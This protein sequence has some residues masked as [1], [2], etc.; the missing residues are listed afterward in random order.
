MADCE[1]SQTKAWQYRLPSG[2]F[3]LRQ[4]IAPYQPLRIDYRLSACRSRQGGWL[5][6]IVQP[7][8][9][10][11]AFFPNPL[12]PAGTVRTNNEGRVCIAVPVVGQD[13]SS[14]T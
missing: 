6:G 11:G 1:R 7:A 14:T 8:M 2:R 3:N 9:R 5:A 12:L 13:Y 10:P 4:S